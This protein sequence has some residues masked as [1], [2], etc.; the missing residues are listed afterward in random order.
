[1]AGDSRPP[2]PTPTPTP[3]RRV[4]ALADLSATAAV[5][6]RLAGLW[7]AGDV[8]ALEGD[9]GAGKTALARAAIRAAAGDPELE[10][11]SPTFTLVQNYRVDAVEVWHF[12][13]Y[14][15]A[16]PEE[17]VELGWDE[18]R[19]GGVVLVEWPDRLG[20]MLPG[21]R[22]SLTLMHPPGGGDEARQLLVDAGPSWR[23]RLADLVAGFEPGV[24]DA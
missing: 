17:V 18:A 12:D 23:D 4:L 11:P 15:L 13:L 22:L 8:I 7:R 24:E 2:I 21:D 20:E 9:L 16:G 19:A 5:A 1:M 6:A 10:V 3:T 14:R